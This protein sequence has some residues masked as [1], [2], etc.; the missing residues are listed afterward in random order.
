MPNAEHNLTAQEAT[1][2]VLVYAYPLLTFKQQYTKLVERIGVNHLGHGRQLLT[3]AARATVKPNTD[4]LYSGAFLDLS[5]DDIY[6]DVP[7]IPEEEY[8]L[9]SFHDLY[10]DNFALLGPEEFSEAGT[11]CLSYA[12]DDNVI[13]QEVR[14]AGPN[15][16][17]IQSSATFVNLVIR[18]LVK[19]DN[20]NTIHA[21]QDAS[22]M[23]AVSI[24]LDEGHDNA[25][26]P[27]MSSIRWNEPASSPAEAVLQ[28]VSQIGRANTPGKL[29]GNSTVQ[30]ILEAAG[31][32]TQS[33]NSLSSVDLEAANRAAL[34]AIESSGQSSLQHQNNGWS[35]VR[36]DL[37][38]TFGS[39]YALRAQIA[40]TGYLMLQAPFA[41][42][43]SWTTN[44]TTGP[45]MQ[46]E[47][48][49]LGADESYVYTFSRRLPLKR[50]GFW[51]LTVY[52]EDGFLIE[53]PL[54]VYSLGD[55][56]DITY[57]D[58]RAVYG[59]TSSD[60][61]NGEFKLLIQPADV[62]P[63]KTWVNNWLPGPS[64]GGRISV[65]LRMYEAADELLDGQ[66]QYP[67]VE[68]QTVIGSDAGN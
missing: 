2:L 49:D 46:G 3:P 57:P 47:M 16:K 23:R 53:N 67:V 62:T 32:R 51:S 6:I 17:R 26:N 10:G 22:S 27:R 25:E 33:L 35:T 5:H 55:R 61:G 19:G 4:T 30:D 31:L 8:V 28:L 1:K 36:A 59:P 11:I 68:K 38:G 12:R 20:L 43:P 14:A 48:L 13:S 15:I 42:Y 50:L 66:W 7:A 63:P 24:A 18:W 64:G 58:G 21:L 45:P 65:L 37:T 56:S 44:G 34:A 40:S 54:G 52:N 60:R 39:N 29:A 9:V 41:V